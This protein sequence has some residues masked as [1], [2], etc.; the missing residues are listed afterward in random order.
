MALIARNQI[1][2]L[3]ASSGGTLVAPA[4]QSFLIKDLYSVPSTNETYLTLYTQNRTVAKYRTKTLSGNHLPMPSMDTASIY[5]RRMG[6]ILS[7]MRKAGLEALGKNLSLPGGSLDDWRANSMD[8]SLPVAPGE[9]FTVSRY[10]EAGNVTL[11]YDIYDQ[12]DIKNTD[13][14]GSASPIIRYLHYV[15][16]AASTAT[17]DMAV[18]TSLLPTG[19]DQWPANGLGVADNATIGLYAIIAA[20]HGKGAA[21]ANKGYT[22]FLK[23]IYGNT[24]LFDIDRNGLPFLGDTSGLSAAGYGNTGSVVGDGTAEHPCNPYILDP[25]LLFRGG[26]TLAIYETIAGW[27]SGGPGAG[28]LGLALLLERKA[29]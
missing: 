4:N 28:E 21:T 7:Q 5:E 22:T 6:T 23:F 19:M 12:A 3:T 25:C 17:G 10:A 27:A 8:L 13:P 18:A 16:N 9:T 15:T 1:K 2:R 29:A 11:V 20:P 24:V 14:N 26:D